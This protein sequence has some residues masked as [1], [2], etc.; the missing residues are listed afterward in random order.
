MFSHIM[1]F[2]KGILTFFK[3]SSTRQGEEKEEHFTP[4]STEAM[5]RQCLPFYLEPYKAMLLS[6][7]EYPKDFRV[8]DFVKQVGLIYSMHIQQWVQHHG[9]PST[10]P[11]VQPI[12]EV[13]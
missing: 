8:D 4:V 10:A 5:A 2:G 13:N 7:G 3:K 6:D 1:E 9:A 12:K 11:P